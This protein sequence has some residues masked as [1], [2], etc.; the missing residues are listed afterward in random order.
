MRYQVDAEG[1]AGLRAAP[2]ARDRARSRP[3]AARSLISAAP[4]VTGRTWPPD[5]ELLAVAADRPHPAGRRAAGA[6]A[7]P[8]SPSTP[9][10]ATGGWPRTGSGR[11]H[12]GRRRHPG[13][14]GHR[15]PAPR[16]GERAF[17]LYCGV[18]LFAGALVDAGVRVWGVEWSRP[19]DRARP[20]QRG[21]G[22]RFT[23]GQVERVA[24]VRCRSA[25]TWSSSTRP[26]PAPARTS[27]TQI[28]AR[29]PRAIAYVACDPAALARD[30]RRGADGGYRLTS[31]RGVRPVPDDP[32]P[33]S[34]RDP[35]SARAPTV[36]TPRDDLEAGRW[37]GARAAR[38]LA[39]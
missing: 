9:P 31:I 30:L 26:G 25:P 10:A 23:A 13:R 6:G 34:G 18:G 35:A 17:D 22:A 11:C 21:R 5:T 38:R 37:P 12:P 8:R 39:A 29:R 24:S 2:V 16:A 14:G 27:S 4:A 28:I 36:K 1:R 19:A 20:P 15:R 33:R 3:A 32:P 7:A